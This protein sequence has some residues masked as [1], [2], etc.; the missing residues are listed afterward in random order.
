[1]TY[2][3]ERGQY[4]LPWLSPGKY[5][6]AAV[7]QD[8][9]R[10]TMQKD[11][12]P[13][14]R[15]G[16]T[17]RSTSPYITRRVLPSGEVVEET[18][19]V[20]YNGG[21]T[22]LDQAR[23]IDLQAGMSASAVDIPMA[24]GHLPV[25][26]IRGVAV[27]STGQPIAGS[28]LMLHPQRWSPSVMIVQGTTDRAGN[29]DLATPPGNYL[30]SLVH[31]SADRTMQVAY[32][33]VAV[34]GSNVDGIRVIPQPAATVNGRIVMEGSTFGQSVSTV[35]VNLRRVPDI[36]RMPPPMAPVALSGPVALPGRGAPGQLELP[37]AFPMSVFAGEYTASVDGVPDGFYVKSFRMG[38]VDLMTTSL[39]IAGGVSPDAI[40]VVLASDGGRAYGRVGNGTSAA[41]T[42]VVV[43][44]VPESAA[45]RQRTELYKNT[46]TDA[47]GR[48]EFS[49][50]R[51][52]RYKLFAWEYAEQGIWTIASVLQPLD[53]MG[54]SIEV[55]AKGDVETQLTMLP[56]L[57]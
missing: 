48:Y 32:Q 40:D 16:L 30:L 2:T 33:P 5:Y 25:H 52:G 37:P 27:D 50:V 21:V 45:D 17:D 47:A 3:D 10:K 19:A 53:G 1:V 36:D 8:P 42:N 56:K 6:V 43:V 23:P 9:F 35:R 13:A 34:S 46:M 24:A 55:N 54:K 44:L 41:A 38:G 31:R 11:S 57:R 4:R 39:R 7:V 18:Y 29:F 12:S 51:P 49:N 20:V 14:G 28:A 15:R 26:H 22:D